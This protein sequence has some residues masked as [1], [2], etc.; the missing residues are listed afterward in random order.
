MA[1]PANAVPLQQE[2]VIERVLNAPRE[3]VFK[4][5]TDPDHAA[6]MVGAARISCEVRAD[7]RSPR[8]RVAS[9]PGVH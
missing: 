4:V 7:G 2:L 5:W 8:R 9:L 3:L 6:T 1:M